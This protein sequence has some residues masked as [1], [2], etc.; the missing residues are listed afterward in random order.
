MRRIIWLIL[1]AAVLTLSG[2]KAGQDDPG[3][4][5]L[6]KCGVSSSTLDS[7]DVA[8]IDSTDFI[9]ASDD[10]PEECTY[11][12]R[13]SYYNWKA[14]F[15]SLVAA[16]S[17][18]TVSEKD[19]KSFRFDTKAWGAIFTGEWNYRYPLYGTFILDLELPGEKG[20]KL[21][22]NEGML[23]A[24]AED[25]IHRVLAM[26][27]LAKEKNITVSDEDYT[28]F[29]EEYLVDTANPEAAALARY[30]CMED[31]LLR[32][33]LPIPYMPLQELSRIANSRVIGEAPAQGILVP[34]N[35]D[36]LDIFD[37]VTLDIKIEGSSGTAPFE[38]K[39][40][41][42]LY[43]F[44]TLGDAAEKKLE[45]IKIGDTV[46]LDLKELTDG[47]YSCFK[48]D[49]KMILSVKNIQMRQGGDSLARYGGSA[50]RSPF[51]SVS[52]WLLTSGNNMLKPC[53][54]IPE[55]VIHF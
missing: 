41:L 36:S 35:H 31:K 29:C 7:I 52:G 50:E 14:R 44:G 39:D 19:K 2:C 23:L 17:Q 1:L 27:A 49:G 3:K 51:S 10:D 4:A 20:I 18:A 46:T 43:G 22:E 8:A 37:F 30:C 5:F 6:K 47:Y 38:E 33:Y 12:G 16:N 9:K 28:K 45:G 21:G 42:F 26:E 55:L 40:V 48:G 34:A 54:I 15:V 25:I 24:P 53:Y 13:T 32:S 11:S